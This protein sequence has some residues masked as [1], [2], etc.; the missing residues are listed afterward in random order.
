MI[1]VTTTVLNQ[2]K[3][4]VGI[5]YL[6]KFSAGASTY[7]FTTS[8]STETYNSETYIPG[9]LDYNAIEDV[10][11][12]SDPRINNT[13]IGI[14][15]ADNTILSAFLSGGWM[16]K[17]CQ[18][19][20]VITSTDGV[21]ILTKVAFDGLLSDFSIDANKSKVTLTVSSIWADYQKVSGIKTNP[22]SQQRY[23][24][25]DTAFEH[26]QSAM[27]KLY[28]GA[29]APRNGTGSGGGAGNAPG[30]VPGSPIQQ[31]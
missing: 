27:K 25:T 28:W 4:A 23:Y 3:S 22:K 14:D 20:K 5:N 31:F 30:T 12:T 1:N 6:V 24:A 2:L 26:S 19:I 17:P 7:R 9:Y 8:D 18:I 21:P 11:V 13:K 15:A 16:N 10:E 29:D